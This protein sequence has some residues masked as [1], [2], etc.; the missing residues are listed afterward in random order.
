LIVAFSTLGDAPPLQARTLAVEQ[1]YM[2]VGGRIPVYDMGRGAAVGILTLLLVAVCV[3]L[4]RR[5][6]RRERIEF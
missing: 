2:T 3:V 5:L 1:Y 4:I 6:M